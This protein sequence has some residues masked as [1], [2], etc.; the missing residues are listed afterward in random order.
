MVKPFRKLAALT[1]REIATA[2]HFAGVF[3]QAIDK[4]SDLAK[5]KEGR[6]MRKLALRLAKSDPIIMCSPD[7]WRDG[8]LMQTDASSA[9]V[10]SYK[11]FGAP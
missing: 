4:Q 3:S 9:W 6:Q 1:I 7:N 2:D 5:S 10:A 8:N 11:I